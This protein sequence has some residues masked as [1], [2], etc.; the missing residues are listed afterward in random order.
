MRTISTPAAPTESKLMANSRRFLRR[1]AKTLLFFFAWL[2]FFYL[3]DRPA[4]AAASDFAFEVSFDEAI[5]DKPFT[6]RVYLFFSK[7]E[8]SAPRFGP[9]WFRPE[10]FLSTQVK[11]WQPGTPLKIAPGDLEDLRTFPKSFDQVSL[12]G[13]YA[14][15]VVRFNPH[16][17]EVGQGAGNG[18]SNVVQIDPQAPAKTL[19]LRVDQLVEP[20]KFKESKWSKEVVMRSPLLSEFYGHD[21]EMKAAVILP[22]SY[23][24]QPQR[25]YP[26]IYQIPGFGG[27]H[28]HG[29]RSKPVAE[30]N[31]EGV[32][33]MRVML[34]PNC[35]RGHHVF[36]DSANNG[37][38]G[39]ALTEELIPHIDDEFRTIDQP[40]ARFLTGHSSGGWS[41]LWLQVAYPD[42]FGG[43]WSTA[44]D[45]VDFRDFQQIDLYSDGENMYVDQDGQKRPLARMNNQ[46]VLWYQNFADMEWALDYGGQLH[47]FEAVFSP[48]GKDGK[49]LSVW[50]RETGEVDTEVAKTWEKYDIRL[51]LEQ[52]WQTLG[53][54]LAGKIHVF[55]GDED[56]FY[57]DGAT[58]LL[59]EALSK[60]GSDA[61]VEIYPGKD[62]S[63]LMTPELMARIRSEMVAA[64]LREYPLGG[65]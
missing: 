22:A 42:F 32:E 4:P 44:P 60:L 65:P 10:P 63:S 33:F 48:R 30:K 18:F 45:P 20:Q 37:P 62:H 58:V 46:P 17:R 54:K 24:D 9:N 56:T 15:A 50:D 41:S 39:Q 27:T 13:L 61:V 21:V 43:T 28:L 7:R 26:V 47:S 35:P 2:L 5:H 53:P 6:G 49:P 59:K 34:D 23:Y 16:E 57:L 29:R 14:Q 52:N 51:I 38:V 12:D 19:H 8:A 40:A 36:A 31:E 11:D 64:F 25:R 3:S 1:S 55:M